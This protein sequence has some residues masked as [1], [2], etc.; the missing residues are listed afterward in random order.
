MLLRLHH[1]D[2]AG[3]KYSASR[4]WAN[5]AMNFSLK[6]FDQPNDSDFRSTGLSTLPIDQAP[7]GY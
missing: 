3:D 4:G 1:I 7:G 6:D 5:V 2:G